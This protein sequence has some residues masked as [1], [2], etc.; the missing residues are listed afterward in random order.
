V[1]RARQRPRGSADLLHKEGTDLPAVEYF[2]SLFAYGEFDVLVFGF[3]II[4][5]VELY[6]REENIDH[7]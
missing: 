6:T 4:E 1:L 7:L 3:Q 2:R 5:F